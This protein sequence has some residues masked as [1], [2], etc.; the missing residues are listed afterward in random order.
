[1]GAV[2]EKDAPDNEWRTAR[3]WPVPAHRTAYYLH[4]GGKLSTT[5]P[6]QAGGGTTFAAD[7]ANPAMV[8]GR[9]FPGPTDARA[10][11]KHPDV[12]TFT[13]DVLTQPVEWTGKVRAE[14]WA[15]ST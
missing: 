14:L 9:A 10:F 12:R 13:S 7:P 6:A 1:M 8:P 4:D 3:D 2:R 5:A 11:E 15:S